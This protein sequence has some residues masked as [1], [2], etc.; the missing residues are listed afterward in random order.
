LMNKSRAYIISGSAVSMPKLI[1]NSRHECIHSHSGDPF[2][3]HPPTNR[4]KGNRSVVNEYFGRSLG[5]RGSIG[6]PLSSSDERARTLGRWTAWAPPE[7]TRCAAAGREQR[8]GGLYGVAEPRTSTARLAPRLPWSGLLPTPSI[9]SPS[10]FLGSC[11]GGNSPVASWRNL[12]KERGR[13]GGERGGGQTEAGAR[14]GG[15]G[16]RS[17]AHNAN[18]NAVAP[19][20]FFKIKLS[21]HFYFYFTLHK[22]LSR[23]VRLFLT[24]FSLCQAFCRQTLTFVPR[25]TLTEFLSALI[26]CKLRS[27]LDAL[28]ILK[29]Y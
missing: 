29:L 1:R 9:P 4:S 12:P 3:P 14:K 20:Q 24:W 23:T 18:L 26:L 13:G 25:S 15:G 27:C 5:R 17:I 28:K 6:R 16:S 8:V 19:F 10:T 22:V 2:Y 21:H 11:G 7:P